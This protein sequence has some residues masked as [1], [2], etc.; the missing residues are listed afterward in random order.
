MEKH[1]HFYENHSRIG[2]NRCYLKITIRSKEQLA[3]V[4]VYKDTLLMETIRFPENG[5][6]RKAEEVPNI[7]S[8]EKVTQKELDTALMLIEQLTDKFDPEKYQ[9]DYRTALL[10]LI[11]KKKNGENTV[12]ATEKESKI[13]SDMTDLM[14]CIT[15]IT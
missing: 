13:P 9:D 5:K 11:E 6:V 14:P 15:S 12:T 7:P 4:R 10:E 1:M 3:I 8:E 2:E